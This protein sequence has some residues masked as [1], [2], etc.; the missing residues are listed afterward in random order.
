MRADAETLRVIS[1]NIANSDT[2]AYRRQI[3]V[4]RTGFD[5]ILAGANE[6]LQQLSA[7]RVDVAHDFKPGTLKSTADPLHL[8]LDGPGFFMLQSPQGPVLT[9]RGDFRLDADGTLVA[10]TGDPVLG[11]NG[12]IHLGTAAAQIATDGSV[13]V[14]ANVIDQI[15]IVQVNDSPHLVA[16]GDGT[17]T[18][19]PGFINEGDVGATVRQGF[20]ETSNVAAVTEMVRLMETVRHFEAEQRFARAYDGLLDQAIRELGKVG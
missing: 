7:A 12:P 11:V 16:V 8:A 3:A 1:Q 15:R 2:I 6:S 19:D 5:A 20:L 9:R 17:F 14:D 18:A 10:A 13:R 4:T